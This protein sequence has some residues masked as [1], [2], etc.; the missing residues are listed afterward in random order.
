MTVYDMC[1]NHELTRNVILKE[2]VIGI[3]S[4]PNLV[5]NKIYHINYNSLAT[6]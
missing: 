2:N 6:F 4:D 5:L 1:N 3:T